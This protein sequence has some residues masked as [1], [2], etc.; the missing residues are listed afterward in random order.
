MEKNLELRDYQEEIV[1]R[2][3]KAYPNFLA[4]LSQEEYWDIVLT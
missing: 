2:A 3:V 1:K 4:S